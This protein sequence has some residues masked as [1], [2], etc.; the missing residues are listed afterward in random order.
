MLESEDTVEEG[1]VKY[2]CIHMYVYTYYK[3]S[4]YDRKYLQ[5]NASYFHFVISDMYKKII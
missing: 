1:T 2:I 3:L 4:I 5:N